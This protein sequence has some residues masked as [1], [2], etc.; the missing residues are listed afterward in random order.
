MSHLAAATLVSST[1]GALS[2]HQIFHS[3]A[4]LNPNASVQVLSGVQSGGQQ[5]QLGFEDLPM[6]T[7]TVTTRTS[8]SASTPPATDSSSPESWRTSVIPC[9]AQRRASSDARVPDLYELLSVRRPVKAFGTHS[10][11]RD[12]RNRYNDGGQ[13]VCIL[14]PANRCGPWHLPSAHSCRKAFLCRVW[15]LLTNGGSTTIQQS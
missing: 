13:A 4:S 12:T 3:F 2:G 15:S 5:L 7:A 14:T 1:Q 9:G 8:W 11:T 10:Q 6:A